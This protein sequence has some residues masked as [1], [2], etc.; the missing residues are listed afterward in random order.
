MAYYSFE[1]LED[2]TGLSR[3]T[4]QNYLRMGILTGE[5]QEGKKAF[6]AEQIKQLFD[7]PFAWPAIKA[8]KNQLIDDF[9]TA[10]HHSPEICSIVSLPM[11]SSEKA[12]AASRAVCDYLKAEKTALFF[13]FVF[14]KR[15]KSAQ[16]VF[17]GGVSPGPEG[18]G[19]RPWL[20]PISQKRYPKR[21]LQ[22]SVS[23][24]CGLPSFIR[25][26]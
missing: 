17:R 13:N 3:R 20:H 9:L 7:S 16:I 2:I 25:I 21:R 14:E 8:K 4:L 19:I 10:E 23:R 15:K 24:C 5:T 1:D 22:D 6:S 12:N 26:K 11:D 18:I